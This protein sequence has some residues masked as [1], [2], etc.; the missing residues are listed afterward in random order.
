MASTNRDN[1][2]VGMLAEPGNPYDG[3]ILGR[4]IDQ[5]Q[6][7]AGYAVQRGFVNCGYRGH[8]VE[9]PRC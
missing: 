7:I 5:V 4:A 3:H 8:K 9:S 2:V 6:R 1:F